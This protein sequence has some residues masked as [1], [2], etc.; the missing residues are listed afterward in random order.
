M[1][2][3]IYQQSSHTMKEISM[4]NSEPPFVPFYRPYGMD[5]S[6]YDMAVRDAQ[7]E[8]DR[9]YQMKAEYEES[10]RTLPVIESARGVFKDGEKYEE[11]KDYEVVNQ[12]H[13]HPRLNPNDKI[14]TS[15]NGLEFHAYIA[16]AL[17]QVSEYE[18]WKD[19]AQ[20]VVNDAMFNGIHV[21][22]TIAELKSKYFIHRK[23][24]KR[25]I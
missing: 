8:R 13:P 23:S 6:E 4:D 17:H 19:V 7:K 12:N 1:P 9:Y 18:I 20:T 14:T 25:G 3:S 15:N 5:D 22:K 10:L 16:I 11:G 2:H 21:S 24:T